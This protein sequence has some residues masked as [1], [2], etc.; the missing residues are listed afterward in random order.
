LGFGRL[1]EFSHKVL[2]DTGFTGGK[3]AGE[4]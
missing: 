2:S 1:G 3:F 4:T